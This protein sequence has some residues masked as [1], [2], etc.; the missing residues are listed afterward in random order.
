[1]A[2]VNL[3]STYLTS[4]S[5][6]LLLEEPAWGIFSKLAILKQFVD[7]IPLVMRIEIVASWLVYSYFKILSPS[8]QV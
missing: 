8:S 2:H 1:M 4:L 6:F 7:V 5:Y 3:T